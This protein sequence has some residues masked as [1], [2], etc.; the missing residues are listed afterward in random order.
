MICNVKT[1]LLVLALLMASGSAAPGITDAISPEEYAVYSSLLNSRLIGSGTELATIADRTDRANNSYVSIPKE[2]EADLSAKS[3]EA[4]ALERKFNIRV[5]YLLLSQDQ[6]NG[7]IF[8]S[9]P[10]D[11]DKYWKLYPH[12]TGV[13]T[14]SRVGF[15]S[16]KTRAF[17]YAAEVCGPLC[18]SGY[19]FVLEKN[20]G[21]WKLIEEKKV[22]IS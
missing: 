21:V 4:Y 20:K 7:A 8:S 1:Y 14:F 11:W 3:T 15:N 13:L 16:T 17:V 2:F 12:G 6:I 10:K 5:K 19:T 18:G 22:W 9:D